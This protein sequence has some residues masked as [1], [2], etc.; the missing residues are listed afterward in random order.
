MKTLSIILPALL[1]L[2]PSALWASTITL[3]PVPDVETEYIYPE[4]DNYSNAVVTVDYT[5]MDYNFRANIQAAGLKRDFTYQVKLGGVPACL[6]GDD[7]TNEKIGY[8][9]RWYCVDCN[10]STAGNNR[11][12]AQ[13][14][15]NKALPDDDPDKECIVGYLVFD[16]F[17][18]DENGDAS[19][20]VETDASYHVLWCGP[21]S[22]SN[23]YLY[24]GYTP[25]GSYCNEGQ[26]CTYDNVVPEIERSSFH[27][28]PDGQ[29][30]DIKM[31]LTEESFHQDCG[32]WST[33]LEGTLSFEIDINYDADNDGCSNLI[34]PNPANWSSDSDQ[35]GYG[36]DCDCNDEESAAN[37]GIKET[38]D[39]GDACSDTVDN[40]CDGFIDDDDLGCQGTPG[41]S[42]MEGAVAEASVYH[43]PLSK[44]S[45]SIVNRILMLL[46][47]MGLILAIK[48]IRPSRR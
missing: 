36:A 25:E 38:L 33:V 31:S 44:E 30:T 2:C 13:Y 10:G 23:A 34:D 39:Y 35:D 21:T 43:G 46:L 29:Y 16:Y 40:D 27:Y 42:W 41:T 22:G 4:P 8:S 17:V 5:E 6:G 18:A 20:E 26:Y 12:D 45:S 1:L 3:D 24:S 32:T 11:S 14:E 15:A 48:I 7:E 9:G 28:L 47:P 19:I 37:P